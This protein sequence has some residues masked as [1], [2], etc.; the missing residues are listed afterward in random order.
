MK[1][2]FHSLMVVFWLCATGAVGTAQTAAPAERRLWSLWQQHAKN[3]ADH[4]RVAAACLQFDT[5]A[6][7]TPF[8]LVARG[9]A[10]WHMLKA[11]DTN[12]AVKLFQSMD[13]PAIEDKTPSSETNAPAADALR[14]AGMNMARTWL[15]R[16][17]RDQAGKALREYYLKHVE[18]PAAMQFLG[19]LPPGQR[20]PLT[21]RWGLPWQYHTTG[22]KQLAGLDGQRYVLQSAMLGN[23]SSAAAALARDYAGRINIKRA[24]VLS[25]D[26]GGILELVLQPPAE[27]GVPR[28]SPAE[29]GSTKTAADGNAQPK[30]IVALGR[31]TGD[32]CA[33][34]IG[35]QFLIFA[36]R[37]HW[38]VW[39]RQ[40]LAG[41]ATAPR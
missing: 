11:G 14:E 21:D 27:A 29:A 34:F 26:G 38:L 30:V 6:P 36:D 8:A 1:G 22:F 40:D 17:D 24:R 33:A 2:V 39:P 20:P 32:I 3:P 7:D 15:T 31:R 28:R 16:I 9:L 13:T 37:D 18:Y 10:A 4:A 12:A 19:A 35:T 5:D 25:S 23:D 41:P